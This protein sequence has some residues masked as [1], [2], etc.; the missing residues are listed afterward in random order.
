METEELGIT[1]GLQD[2]VVQVLEGCI[3]MNFDQDAIEKTGNGIYNRVDV[4]LLPPLFMAYSA[5]PEEIS[6]FLLH[7]FALNDTPE[8]FILM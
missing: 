1:A 5:F 4:R 8:R 2:R 6:L 3:Q 7:T